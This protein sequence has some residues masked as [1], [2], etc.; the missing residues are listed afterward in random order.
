MVNRSK[1]ESRKV[2]ISFS[3]F[4]APETAGG[5]PEAARNESRTPDD[6]LFLMMSLYLAL[7]LLAV[8]NYDT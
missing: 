2:V 6:H 5:F 4:D 8:G 3:F 1:A 7:T